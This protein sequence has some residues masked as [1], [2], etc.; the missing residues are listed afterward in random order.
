LKPVYCEGGVL[1]GADVA[2]L[3]V[4]SPPGGVPRVQAATYTCSGCRS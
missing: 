4:F 1:R 3:N 2:S